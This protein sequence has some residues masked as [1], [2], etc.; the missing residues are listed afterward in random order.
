MQ[1]VW[2]RLSDGPSVGFRGEAPVR[3]VADEDW[4]TS[5]PEDFCK[6][7]QRF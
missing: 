6:L 5:F 4:R 3:G 2:L 7:M 1:R